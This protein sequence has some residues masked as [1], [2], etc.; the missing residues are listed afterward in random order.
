MPFAAGNMNTKFN[1]FCGPWSIQDDTQE[2]RDGN[3]T[4]PTGKLSGDRQDLQEQ[5]G[6]SVS[7]WAVPATTE[8]RQRWWL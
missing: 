6:K 8:H 2:Q 7:A 5:E 1:W 3:W 4:N